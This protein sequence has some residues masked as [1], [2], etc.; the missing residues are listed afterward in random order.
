M[1]DAMHIVWS[2]QVCAASRV[3]SM[4]GCQHSNHY[5]SCVP[6]ALVA[7][8]EDTTVATGPTPQLM[9]GSSSAEAPAAL[10]PSSGYDA[11][12]YEAGALSGGAGGAA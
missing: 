2:I 11:A 3:K 12:W 4:R 5:M 7:D 1:Y 6:W 9:G 10:A 8:T